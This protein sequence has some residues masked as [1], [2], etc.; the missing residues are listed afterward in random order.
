MNDDYKLK[1]DYLLKQA[2][3]AA[4]IK[5]NK[6]N[7][8]ELVA[9]NKEFE[10]EHGNKQRLLTEL[11]LANEENAFA[12]IQA[13]NQELILQNE[14]NEKRTL[15]MVAA[16]KELLFQ[17]KEKEKR[18]AS[19]LA[20]NKKLLLQNEEKEKQAMELMI[21]N[22]ALQ[23]AEENFR[24]SISESP[25]GIRIVTID[26]ETIYVNKAFLE[27]YEIDSLEA[28][29]KVP[30][31]NR[32]TPE[33]YEHQ[34]IRNKQRRKGHQIYN[35]EL[36]IIRANGEIRFVKVWRKEVLWNGIKHFQVINLDITDQKRA[37][38]ALWNSQ[39]EMRKFA[40]HL[41]NIREEERKGLAREIHDDLGQALIALKIDMGL[42]RKKISQSL[43]KMSLADMLD[44]VDMLVSQINKTIKIMRR[45]M[46]GLR[47]EIIDLLGFIDAA[48][49]YVDE[50]Q[51]WHNLRCEFETKLETINIDPEQSVALFRI[52]QEALT[53]VAIHSQAT[54]VKI[55]LHAAPDLLIMEVKDNGIG[56]DENNIVKLDSYGMI[57][58]KER[59]LL[60]GGKVTISGKS[61]EGTCVMV[62]MPYSAGN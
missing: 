31:I 22:E 41:Q 12:L 7:A 18:E 55:Q 10:S 21:A 39:Q 27:I 51:E 47:P 3:A 45:I 62:E 28:F 33:S 9:I 2:E 17:I 4:L 24:R 30:A 38:E 16:N 1:N 5:A 42:L 44:K 48:K 54:E 58:M 46:N 53:N 11:I 35:Y 52:L 60:L 14:K 34:V 6:T 13:T 59:V 37:E 19:L 50:F 43:E 23:H 25:L 26:E 56:F 40:G 36:S 20:A 29:K 49:S 32:Y 8:I 15:E 61:G 57:G